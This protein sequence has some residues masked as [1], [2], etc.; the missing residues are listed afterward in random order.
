LRLE[1]DRNL[2]QI[3]TIH[4]S[5]GLEY[6]VVFCPFLWD[7]HQPSFGELEGSEYHDDDGQPVIDFRSDLDD[8]EAAEIKRRAARGEGRRVHAPALR[9]PDASGVPL[10]PGRR[11]L[12]D[13]DLRQSLDG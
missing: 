1:S 8:S 7:G 2:V 5:K 11:L 10:L 3:V 9:R 13:P 4:K 6:G 12:R